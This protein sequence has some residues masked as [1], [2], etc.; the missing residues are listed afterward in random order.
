MRVPDEVADAVVEK[1]DA[2]DIENEDNRRGKAG[3]E[4]RKKEGGDVS[5]KLLQRG[6]P[7]AVLGYGE[8][9]RLWEEEQTKKPIV[10]KAIPPSRYLN[11][12]TRAW[13]L[14]QL[15][16]AVHTAMAA[17][18]EQV[19]AMHRNDVV[20]HLEGSKET[21]GCLLVC[22]RYFLLSHPFVGFA[23]NSAL[24]RTVI[25]VAEHREQGKR[26]KDVGGEKA[27]E[28]GKP[29]GVE[30][31]PSSCGREGSEAGK[32]QE[33]GEGFAQEESDEKAGAN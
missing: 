11:L 15:V 26:E 3:A 17:S 8:R 33:D 9:R 19:C 32:K 4:E 27:D 14:S 7:R 20:R 21:L 2:G 12:C 28:A 6:A 31:G 25:T 30:N 22:V 10:E 16:W 18:V 1:V 29:K 23:G 13:V 5:E 24:F